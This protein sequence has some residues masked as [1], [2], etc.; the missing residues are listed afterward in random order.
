MVS[1][2]TAPVSPLTLSKIGGGYLDTLDGLR[3][4]VARP[5]RRRMARSTRMPSP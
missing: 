5:V 2:E 1:L 4:A 3:A